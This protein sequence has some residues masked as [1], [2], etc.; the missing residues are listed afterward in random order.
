M[1]KRWADLTEEQKQRSRESGARYRARNAERLRREAREKYAERRDHITARKRKARAAR[2]TKDPDK[3]RQKRRTSYLN[4]G[5]EYFYKWAKANPDKVAMAQ[6][7]WREKNPDRVKELQL[8][9]SYGITKAEYDALLAQQGG[10]C[11]ICGKPETAYDSKAQRTR[12]LAVDHCHATGRIR[13]LL[14]FKCNVGIGFL[15][16]SPMLAAAAF[17]YLQRHA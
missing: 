4:G 10:L 3:Y 9:R 2:I 11:A 16:D 14:C 15:R 1:P 12:Y 5:R 6:L 17:E 8:L 7:K 13:G